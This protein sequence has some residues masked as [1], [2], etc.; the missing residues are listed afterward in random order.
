MSSTIS[1]FQLYSEMRV[2]FTSVSGATP[3]TQL[4]LSFNADSAGLQ[5]DVVEAVDTGYTI[6]D[7][8]G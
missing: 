6:V 8:Q 4:Y 3:D 7:D 2:L 5:N 1:L